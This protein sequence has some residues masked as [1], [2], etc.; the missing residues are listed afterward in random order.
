MMLGVVVLKKLQNNSLQGKFFLLPFMLSL[1]DFPKLL[2]Q[3][4]SHL[5]LPL[6]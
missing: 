2:V 5:A 4:P 1:K 6:F 3:S